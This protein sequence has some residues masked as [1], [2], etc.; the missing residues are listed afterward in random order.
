MNPFSPPDCDCLPARTGCA[1][2]SR[3]RAAA[4]QFL[5]YAAKDRST[6]ARAPA[7]PCRASDFWLRSNA[8]RR[9]AFRPRFA[10]RFA[11]WKRPGACRS[12]PLSTAPSPCRHADRDSSGS[13]D[14]SAAGR[15]R[16]ATPKKTGYPAAA[17][18]AAGRRPAAADFF[19]AVRVPAV[20][21]RLRDAT[22]PA[23]SAVRIPADSAANYS[24]APAAAAPVLRACEGPHPLR[25]ASARHSSAGRSRT[26]SF[27]YRVRDRADFRGPSAC[28]HHRRHPAGPSPLQFPCGAPRPAANTAA[29]SAHAAKHL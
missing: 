20:A 23:A 8:R 17:P 3:S 27:P 5:R 11:D 10:G 19:A 15:R 25:A 7:F 4:W 18:V 28:H 21:S 24:P 12:S 22:F 1:S 13:A 6:A 29:P 26:D 2:S 14:G 9:G 16:K